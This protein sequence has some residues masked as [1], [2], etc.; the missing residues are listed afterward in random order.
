MP[1][2]AAS[3]QAPHNS[4]AKGACTQYSR[5]TSPTL[6][7]WPRAPCL[8]LASTDR[9]HQRGGCQP[10]RPRAPP[11]VLPALGG[12]LPEARLNLVIFHLRRGALNE[13]YALVRDAAPATPQEYI[14]KVRGR[15]G[16]LCSDGPRHCGSAK[17]SQ[18]DLCWAL[19]RHAGAHYGP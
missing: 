2:D 10:P 15:G 6:Q 8:A 4:S 17:A 12:V 14:L 19:D 7:A 18:G 11:Q 13:A 9:A 3:L 16:G 1:G 5:A